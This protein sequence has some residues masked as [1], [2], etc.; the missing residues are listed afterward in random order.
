[1]EAAYKSGANSYL[2]K[3]TDFL[4]FKRDIEQMG[5][6]NWLGVNQAYTRMKTLNMH[7]W[8]TLWTAAGLALVA[9][10]HADELTNSIA[11]FKQMTLEQLMNQEV[12][13][14]SRKP[15]P[16]SESPLRNSSD[17]G[18]GYPP[19]RALTLAQALR[20]A[21]NLEV[22]Q[23]NAHDWAITSRG[24]NGAPLSN[25]SLANKFW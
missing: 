3:S 16:L 15:E 20:L 9:T 22:A 11:E 7:R 17:S 10:G 6:S 24:F 23:Q 21:P 8:A 18:R 1:L 14:V 25:N 5:R 19:F 4:R 12:T 13:M 2:I